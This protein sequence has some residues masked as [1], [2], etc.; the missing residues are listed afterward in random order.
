[1]CFNLISA[2]LLANLGCFTE[3]IP[4]S[5]IVSFRLGWNRTFNK[6]LLVG[7]LLFFHTHNVRV[8]IILDY[9]RKHFVSSVACRGNYEGRSF[10]SGCSFPQKL[11][12]TYVDMSE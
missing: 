4:H 1:M 6:L 7:V 12:R 2:F 10:D 3:A 5:T 11:L 9:F 8:T